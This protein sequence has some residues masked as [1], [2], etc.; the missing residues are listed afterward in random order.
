MIVS[1]QLP[2]FLGFQFT[3]LIRKYLCRLS[4]GMYIKLPTAC[5][6]GD[7][8]LPKGTSL[9]TK[10]VVDNSDRFYPGASRVIPGHSSSFYTTTDTNICHGLV[11]I[12][13]V[14]ETDEHFLLVQPYFHYS[15]RDSVMFSPTI[16]ETSYAKSLFIV[17]QLLHTMHS[18]HNTGLCMG[19]IRLKDIL[20]D[21]NMWLH[22]A[23]PRLGILRSKNLDFNSPGVDSGSMYI[24]ANSPD[25][26]PP[27]NSYLYNSSAETTRQQVYI[28]F[29]LYFGQLLS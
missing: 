25:G 10:S 23:S 3:D 20:M 21:K 1:V 12:D 18:L 14:I 22:V 11:P 27:S 13:F 5:T 8:Q 26:V 28:L 9:R 17:Y 7:Q 16:L 19:D 4:P 29:Y 24:T 15:L 2:H 6:E